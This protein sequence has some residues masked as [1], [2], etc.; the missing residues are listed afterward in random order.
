ML[1]NAHKQSLVDLGFFEDDAHV[2]STRELCVVKHRG[3]S[4]L[5]IIY[6]DDIDEAGLFRSTDVRPLLA[7]PVARRFFPGGSVGAKV[8]R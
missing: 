1:Q 7:A 4:F 3:T 5:E 6:Q 8:F 2:N